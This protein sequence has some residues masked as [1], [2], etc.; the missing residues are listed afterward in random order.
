MDKEH[1]TKNVLNHSLSK[2]EE[3]HFERENWFKS[4]EEYICVSKVIGT[5]TSYWCRVSEC[6]FIYFLYGFFSYKANRKEY[7]KKR[8]PISAIIMFEEMQL[9]IVFC[10]F[11]MWFLEFDIWNNVVL[12]ENIWT[13][14]QDSLLPRWDIVI[15]MKIC[16]RNKFAFLP[17]RKQHLY[18]WWNIH[19][20]MFCYNAPSL[21]QPFVSIN[22]SCVCLWH[23]LVSIIPPFTMY[24]QHW[25]FSHT[26]CVHKY[27]NLRYF[28]REL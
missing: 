28:S 24:H 13:T 2:A 18:S 8:S 17:Q 6:V 10:I 26:M 11:Y 25:C 12:L 14:N 27:T 23:S 20:T 4:F 7:M 1:E 15:V 19:L 16:N 3:D 9:I 21:S 22:M 5:I